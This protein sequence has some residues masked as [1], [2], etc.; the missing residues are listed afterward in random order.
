MS[1]IAQLPV[2]LVLNIIEH[3]RPHVPYMD[4]DEALMSQNTIVKRSDASFDIFYAP[5][6]GEDNRRRPLAEENER[7]LELRRARSYSDLDL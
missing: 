6:E 4:T 7:Q 5:E 1:S 2:E 3:L